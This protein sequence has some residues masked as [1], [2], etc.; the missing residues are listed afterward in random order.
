MRSDEG[1]LV[2]SRP[3]G[4]MW[5]GKRRSHLAPR[6]GWACDDL[7]GEPVPVAGIRGR[8]HAVS[9]AGLWGS[10]QTWLP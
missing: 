5:T 1:S 3:I 6:Y 4:R 9:L 10:G 8:L 2:T 7:A